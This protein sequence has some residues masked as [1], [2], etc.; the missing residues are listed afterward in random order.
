MAHHDVKSSCW[1]FKN[2][3][4]TL[5]EN[6]GNTCCLRQG[7]LFQSLRWSSVGTRCRCRRQRS[8]KNQGN[9]APEKRLQEKFLQNWQWWQQ[10]QVDLSAT[11]DKLPNAV[12]AFLTCE[13]PSSVFSLSRIFLMEP[14][15]VQQRVFIV[16]HWR[17]EIFR[18]SL[19]RGQKR[20]CLFSRPMKSAIEGIILDRGSRWPN[21]AELV[22]NSEYPQM[23]IHHHSHYL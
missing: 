10:M 3:S 17:F 12:V 18:W 1:S 6:W 8:V 9:F 23:M 20:I 13:V 2:Y 5:A 11:G 14:C 22:L 15:K 21:N 4:A 19:I 16:T 7:Q